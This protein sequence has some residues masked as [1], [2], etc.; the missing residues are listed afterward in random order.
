M[1]LFT[2]C[3]KLLSIVLPESVIIQM[4]IFSHRIFVSGANRVS[5][6]VQCSAV[7]DAMRLQYVFNAIN[8]YPKKN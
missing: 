3:C 4:I 5:C 8:K 6:A 1:H 2:R 7:R